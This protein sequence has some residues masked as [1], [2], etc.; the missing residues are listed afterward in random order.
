M[1]FRGRILANMSPQKLILTIIIGFIAFT[2]IFTGFGN[3]HLSSLSSVDPNTAL[4]VGDQKIEISR[5]ANLMSQYGAAAKSPEEKNA[6]ASQ[7]VNQ[8]IREGILLEEARNIGWN[9]SDKELSTFIRTSP[10]FLDPATNKF[11]YDT[12]KQYYESI[13]MTEVDFYNNIKEKLEIQ[14]IQNLIFM[15]V[16]VPDKLAIEQ[17]T[18]N[19]TD[20]YL[21]YAV[22]NPSLQFLE[23]KIQ[24]ETDL[25]LKNK[26]NEAQIKNYYDSH[27]KNYFR[28]SQ[29]KVESILISY[30]TAQRAQ[31]NALNKNQWEA[32]K[33]AKNILMQ[34]QKG[35]KFE[36]LASQD[37]DDLVAKKNSGNLGFV[38]ES[39]ID[40]VSLDAIEKLGEKINIQKL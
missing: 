25:F 13:G 11:S 29:I 27:K 34:I 30:K 2:F 8:L 40:S 3:V 6:I 33:Q 4:V 1:A 32:L 16:V 37:N 15:P 39:N 10:L 35:K 7:I 9:V 31:G 19:N 18:I 22:L 38:D 24:T 21:E 5:F 12:F 14:K 17:N 26:N 36:S 28:K 23:K 20:F